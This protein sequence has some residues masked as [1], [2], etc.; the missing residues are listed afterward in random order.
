MGFMTTRKAGFV[1]LLAGALGLTGSFWGLWR[2]VGW[3]AQPFYAYAWWSY[4]FLLDGFCALCR[5]HSLFTRR[6]RLALAMCV[7]SVTFWFFFE[8]LNSRFQNWYYVGVFNPSNLSEL[9]AGGFFAVACFAT[10]LPGLFETYEAL[11]AAGLW[12]RWQGQQPTDKLP[13]WT[14]YAVQALGAAMAL[15]AIFFP[16]YL[17]PLIWGSLTFLV[18][19]WNYR[20]GARSILRD[21]ETRDWGLI[22]RI[23]V[24]GLICGLVWESFNFYAPQKWIYTVRGLENFKLFEMPILGFFGFPG[25]AY[26]SLAAFSLISYFFLGNRTWEHPGDLRYALHPRPQRSRRLLW[27][28][29]VPQCAFWILVGGLIVRVNVGSVQLELVDFQLRDEEIH[30][31]ESIGIQRPRQLLRASEDEAGCANVREVLG[32]NS[33]RLANLVQRVDLY[34]FKGIGAHW[35]ERL[36][37]LGVHSIEDLRRWTPESLYE[38][39]S[40]DT[41]RE[42]H[43]RKL[44]LDLVR[45]WVLASYNRGILLNQQ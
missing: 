36:E 38:A 14:S 9:I 35:G 29:I 1:F 2:D 23:F 18:D 37:G 30:A 11:T 45:V 22:S 39:L 43:T 8:L 12:K 33:R 5:G 21:F 25:L 28:S 31:L 32:W 13:S 34:N 44:R 6:F 15:T 27:L 20:H 10:V 17:A 26:D 19:P 41:R 24:A 40:T 42:V 3:I 16:Y 4:I 7:L